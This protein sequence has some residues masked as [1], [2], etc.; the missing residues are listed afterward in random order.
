MSNIMELVQRSVTNYSG[1][2]LVAFRRRHG[3]LGSC[4]ADFAAWS[5][6]H[7]AGDFDVVVLR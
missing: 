6:D 7:V 4:V 5:A 3:A 2:G 1:L